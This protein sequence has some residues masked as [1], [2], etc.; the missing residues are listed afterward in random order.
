MSHPIT[1]RETVKR[2]IEF[3]GPDRV[4]I[5]GEDTFFACV[6]SY[7]AEL[8]TAM[9]E[10]LTSWTDEWGVEYRR[11]IKETVGAENKGMPIDAPLKDLEDISAYPHWPRIEDDY[12]RQRFEEVGQAVARCAEDGRYL[13]VGWFCLAERLWHLEGMEAA[14]VNLALDPGRIKAILERIERFTMDA[15]EETGRRWPG[16]IDGFYMGDDWGTQSGAL[17]SMKHFR[18]FFKPRYRRLFARAHELGMHTW[19]HSCGYINDILEELIDC[20]LEV[21]NIG[22]PL[23]LGIDAIGSRYAGRIA[24]EVSADIQKMLPINAGTSLEDIAAH[25][26]ELIVRW[27]TTKGGI[28][29]ADYGGYESIGTTAERAECALS[30][31]RQHRYGPSCD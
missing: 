10:G 12:Y 1:R 19:M 13:I 11:P 6:S 7:D 23:A 14:F 20:G 16:R 22:Q 21:V 27:G 4:P 28:I 3:G 9:E 24:F 25:V 18:E 2:A 30:A 26:R 31:F 29:G 17:I 15:L 8:L 5:S